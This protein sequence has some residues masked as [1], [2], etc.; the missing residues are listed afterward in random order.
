MLIPAEVTV[1]A[2]TPSSNNCITI[3]ITDGEI[4][5]NTA[6][7]NYYTVFS[8]PPSKW[9]KDV[10]FA[11][12]TIQLCTSRDEAD[13]WHERHGFYRGD[14]VGLETLWKLSKVCTPQKCDDR[15]SVCV[16][17]Q[18]GRSGMVTN[19]R[20]IT[21]ERLPRKSKRYSRT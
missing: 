19:T 9:W 7:Q 6:L 8:S 10:R 16:A 12:S 11:C 20:T 3:K 18:R 5:D 2:M 14:V 21:S 4:Q 15:E 13:G 1:R 17:D